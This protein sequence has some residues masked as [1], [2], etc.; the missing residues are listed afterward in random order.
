LWY[1]LNNPRSIPSLLNHLQKFALE[2]G[3]KY[4]DPPPDIRQRVRKYSV[5]NRYL[6]QIHPSL[7]SGNLVKEKAERE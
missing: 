6:H 7:S 2:D 3:N 1:P 4:R 5:L